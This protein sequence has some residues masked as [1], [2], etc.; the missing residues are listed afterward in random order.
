[1]IPE[2]KQENGFHQGPLQM[3]QPAML[4]TLSPHFHHHP[5]ICT[6]SMGACVSLSCGF[7]S[8]DIFF[9]SAFFFSSSSTHL[10]IT[11]FLEH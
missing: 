2:L 7:Y 5:H 8:L 1:M 6:D 10:T 3:S 11:K 4:L 9:S